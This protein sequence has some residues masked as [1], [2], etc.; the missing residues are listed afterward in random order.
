MAT[1]A[2]PTGRVR[3]HPTPWRVDPVVMPDD[4]ARAYILDARGRSVVGLDA[5]PLVAAEL[6]VAAAN[7]LAE[8][9]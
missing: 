3:R 8:G 6:I 5:V 4:K 1:K 7:E 2:N 9:G